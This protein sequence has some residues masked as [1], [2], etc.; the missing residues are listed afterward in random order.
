MSPKSRESHL[1]HAN[2]SDIIRHS[3]RY[4]LMVKT[5]QPMA[6][7]G[8]D[9]PDVAW[10]EAVRRDAVIRPLAQSER[11]GRPAVAVAAKQLGLGVSQTDRLLN[12]FRLGPVT[13]TL[14][15]ASG[16]RKK[17]SRLLPRAVEAVIERSIETLYKTRE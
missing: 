6:H 14:I 9:V 16:G 8:P 1:N 7:A 4:P 12:A 3:C 10:N 13:Q 17:G 5:T 2:T 15:V 11:P